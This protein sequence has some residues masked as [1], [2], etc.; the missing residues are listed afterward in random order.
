MSYSLIFL[1]IPLRSPA[2]EAADGLWLNLKSSE[3]SKQLWLLY[4]GVGEVSD[5]GVLDVMFVELAL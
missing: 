1:F 5:L 3:P 4:G 2:V